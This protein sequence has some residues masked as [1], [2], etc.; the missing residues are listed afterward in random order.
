[1]AGLTNTGFERKTR[2]QIEESIN[3]N[4]RQAFGSEF[5]TGDDSSFK[6]LAGPF[7]VELDNIWQETQAAYSAYTR[8]GA[9]G[10]HLDNFYSFRGI[11]RLNAESGT[12]TLMVGSDQSLPDPFTLTGV[13]LTNPQGVS[14]TQTSASD[15]LAS[16]TTH[17]YR[18]L[19]SEVSDNTTYVLT[20][21]DS[22][23]VER[24]FT[25][26]VSPTSSATTFL[27]NLREDLINN[28]TDLSDKIV[29]NSTGLYIGYKSVPVFDSTT[30][31]FSMRF[32]TA[33]GTKFNRVRIR[34]SIVGRVNGSN[35]NTYSLTPSFPGF[36]EAVGANDNTFTN[37]RNVETDAEFRVRA[38]GQ[39]STTAVNSSNRLSAA[40][41]ALTGVSNTIVY[42]NPTPTATTQVNEPYAAH[43]I[44]FGG[45]AN[46]IASTILNNSPLNIRY[47]GNR[48]V[49]VPNDSGTNTAVRF[50]FGE[51]LNIQIRVDYD[52]NDDV[53]L[54]QNEV[55]G[56]RDAVASYVNGLAVGST[57]S[58]F[59]VQ[60]VVLSRVPVGRINNL[61]INVRESGTNTAFSQ[62]DFP[63]N[64][65]QRLNLSQ[66]S[67]DFNKI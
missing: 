59:I 21:R 9:E 2:L 47:V 27:A 56:I 51:N 25:Y 46:L 1:M 39:G 57:L 29:S 50:S 58:T 44:V 14:F 67:I 11:A 32:D 10:V 35:G 8:T 52:T 6:Q 31:P 28:I 3:A 62:N 40:L 41:N 63:A 15:V 60:S 36:V 20:I 19:V 30:Q 48:V 16:A 33:L 34:S 49:Q 17:A 43:V 5:N 38:E 26:H 37:G 53:P 18:I 45:D 66:E 24:Q 12:E 65:N 61:V 55:G 13:S 22:Q 7:T 42:Q 54:S 4:A 23:N 64:F